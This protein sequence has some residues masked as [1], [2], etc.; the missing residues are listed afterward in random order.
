MA[1]PLDARH[2]WDRRPRETPRAYGAFITYRD[3][4]P[5][6]S[7]RRLAARDSAQNL[8]QLQTW[9]S[10]HDWVDRC[11]SWDEHLDEERRLTLIEEARE[12]TRR[13]AT[14]GQLMLARAAE[15][16]RTL[17][18][19]T[20]TVTE[21]VKLIDVGSRLERLA[22]GEPTDIGEQRVET[23]G[24]RLDVLALLRRAPQIADIL[25]EIDEMLAAEG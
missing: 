19:Q 16:L 15:R 4:G 13:Q 17:D 3:L 20:L 23:A 7:L 10:A 12:M 21:A 5:T 22:R 11:G 18:P 8:R 24:S 1:N 9:S 2:P 25:D 14:I 6:R